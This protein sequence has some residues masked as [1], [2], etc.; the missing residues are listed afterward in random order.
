[1]KLKKTES[2][3]QKNV[4]VILFTNFL[5]RERVTRILDVFSISQPFVDKLVS[6]IGR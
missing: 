6:V 3:L 1:M 2:F 5:L 4:S